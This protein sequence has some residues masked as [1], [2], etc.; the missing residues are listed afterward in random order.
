MTRSWGCKL[1]D[2]LGMAREYQLNV[3]SQSLTTSELPDFAVEER[4]SDPVRV[5]SKRDFVE[6]VVKLPGN[7]ELVELGRRVSRS[8]SRRPEV[9][10][11][12]GGGV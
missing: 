5:S 7:V 9:D 10:P 11:I 3:P 8:V 6:Y 12:G 1:E 2:P 4:V